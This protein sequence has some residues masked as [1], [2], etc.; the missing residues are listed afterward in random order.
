MTAT[1]KTRR[2]QAEATDLLAALVSIAL[3]EGVGQDE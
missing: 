1:T 3:E 2:G